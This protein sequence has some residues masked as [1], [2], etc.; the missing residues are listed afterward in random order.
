MINVLT[1][2]KY[3]GEQITLL[4]Q[5][6]EENRFLLGFEESYG[7]MTGGHVRDKDAVNGAMIICEMA[8]YYKKAGQDTD[9]R[10]QRHLLPLWC[11]CCQGQGDTPLKAQ[12]E[13]TR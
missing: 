1:G 11:L 2:F 8:E 4:E 7:Y 13:W 3:I 12:K 10:A 5:K 9:R 6:G